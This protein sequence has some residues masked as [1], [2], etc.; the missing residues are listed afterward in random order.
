MILNLTRITR[1]KSDDNKANLKTLIRKTSTLKKQSSIKSEKFKP[2]K[3]PSLYFLEKSKFSEKPRGSAMKNFQINSNNINNNDNYF[4]ELNLENNKS[5]FESKK[6]KNEDEVCCV[7]NNINNINI[8]NN[9]NNNEQNNFDGKDKET[10]KMNSK[11]VNT[12]DII[13]KPSEFLIS[14]KEIYQDDE[15]LYNFNSKGVKFEIIP[16]K[17][18]SLEDISEEVLKPNKMLLFN[19]KQKE[20]SEAYKQEISEIY[21]NEDFVL[22]L[23]SSLAHFLKS[24]FMYY[25]WEAVYSDIQC[26]NS[27]CMVTTLILRFLFAGSCLFLLI[28]KKIILKKLII[29]IIFYIIISIGISACFYVAYTVNSSYVYE[30]ELIEIMIIFLLF[31]SF[32]AVSFIDALALFILIL[33]IRIITMNTMKEPFVYFNLI[34]LIFFIVNLMQSYRRHTKLINNFNNLNIANGRD[35][36]QKNLL[37]HLIPK[38]VKF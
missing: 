8:L 17:R 36:Q 31:N 15:D 14:H 3:R 33:I 23:I 6:L 24:Y 32:S 30:I 22:L 16:E 25:W 10:F 19:K 34:L 13:E 20:L 4:P 28:L 21:S 7:I 18:A 11:N 35:N 27:S 1:L 38:H 2:E 5:L 9:N 12:F 37:L 29:K 26:E